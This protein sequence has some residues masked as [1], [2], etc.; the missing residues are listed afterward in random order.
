MKATLIL[1]WRIRIKK[2]IS[3]SFITRKSKDVPRLFNLVYFSGSQG[4]AFMEWRCE[5]FLL[6]WLETEI[7]PY[8]DKINSIYEDIC[9]VARHPSLNI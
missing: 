6:S 4:S 8:G 2:N 9:F 7:L 1:N 3:G 5:M